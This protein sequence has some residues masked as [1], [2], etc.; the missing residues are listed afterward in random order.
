MKII[1]AKR[2]NKVSE[3]YFSKKLREINEINQKGIQVINLG[4]GSPD[5]EPPKVV[6]NELKTWSSQNSVH[7]YQR[8]NGI[9]ELRLAIKEWSKN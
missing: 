8:Y 5:L 7:G 9:P 1:E 3:Y 6:I 2:L 4:I